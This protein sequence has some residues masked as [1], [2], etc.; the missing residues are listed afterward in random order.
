MTLIEQIKLK[1]TEE[2]MAKRG[3]KREENPLEFV[4]NNP[5]S[6]MNMI[7]EDTDIIIDA[8]LAHLATIEDG[9]LNLNDEVE[10][11][12][13]EDEEEESIFDEYG[14]IKRKA[15]HT[16]SACIF[17]FMDAGTGNPRYVKD[18]RKWLA[19]IDRLGVSDD[20]EIEGSLYYSHDVDLQDAERIECLECE[21]K[22]DLLL[23]VH[24][25]TKGE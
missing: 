2:V 15:T 12:E 9:Q 22:E 5:D 3:W 16:T 17:V 21:S 18:V 6:Q 20:A 13:T 11:E 1:I 23:T 10:E 19:K 7:Y 4:L 14:H 25:C 24:K 8:F